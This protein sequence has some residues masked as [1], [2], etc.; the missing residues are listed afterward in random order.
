MCG[1][2]LTSD[3]DSRMWSGQ[4]ESVRKDIECCYGI[5]KVRFKIL[6]Y[7]IQFHSRKGK[8]GAQFVVTHLIF[9]LYT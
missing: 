2:K 7:P 1:M 4:M 8:F 5:L 3:S 9:I 6:A